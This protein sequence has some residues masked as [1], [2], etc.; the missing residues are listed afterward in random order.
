MAI[1]LSILMGQQNLVKLLP[2]FRSFFLFLC[3]ERSSGSSIDKRLLRRSKGL[4][5]YS[6]H[7][8]RSIHI[9]RA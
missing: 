2:S 7:R 1:V 4:F 9:E 3:F 5:G 6:D 8:D